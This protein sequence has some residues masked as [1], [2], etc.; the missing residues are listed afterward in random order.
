MISFSKLGEYGRFGN[1][2]FQYAFLRTQA[3]KLGVKFYCPKWI[4]DKIFD[5]NDQDEKGDVFIPKLSYVE[6]AY[7]HGFNSESLE[8]PLSTNVSSCNDLFNCLKRIM[9]RL[10]LYCNPLPLGKFIGIG[11]AA[12]TRTIT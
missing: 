6:N 3:K 5:L 12:N 7:M 11:R 2:L 8:E 4:G 9:W 1:Q 10:S